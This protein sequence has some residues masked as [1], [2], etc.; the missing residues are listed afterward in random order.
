MG[1]PKPIEEHVIAKQEDIVPSN[2]NMKVIGVCNPGGTLFKNNEGTK[3]YLLLRVTEG[4]NIDFS[5]HIAFPR[6]IP[7]NKNKYIV[8]WE[9]ERLGKDAKLNG[10]NSLV[11]VES[12]E[13]V[14][15]TSI[16]HFRLAESED[17]INFTISETPTLFPQ[18]KYEEFGIEDARITKLSEP[19]ELDGESYRYIITYVA[20]SEAYDVCTAF[21]LTNDFKNF[22]RIPKDNPG[23][24]FYAPSKDV[25]IFPKKFTNPRTQKQ[26]YLA[27]TRPS[28]MAR[29]MVPSIFLSYSNDLIHWGDHKILVKGDE[30]GHVGAGPA[31]IECEEGWLV[32]DH[33]HRHLPDGTK[34]YIGRAY[35]LDKQNPQKIIKKSNE[36]IEPHLNLD[37]DS[38]VEN[39]TFPSAAMIKNN[40]IFIYTGEEDVLTAVHIYDLKEFMNFLNPVGEV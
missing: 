25:V 27:L 37:V 28:G 16:S 2:E 38:I 33:Q 10:P 12:E 40:K 36:F 18:T 39:V 17:G 34:E 23:I 11:T 29:Y 22:V 31:P 13:R 3:F 1:V 24:I 7:N 20:C 9:W 14:K 6:A 15:P 19:I 8:R 30:K 5:G 4:P 21:A 26:D 32:I 35:L